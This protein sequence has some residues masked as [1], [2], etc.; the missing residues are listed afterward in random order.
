[1]IFSIIIPM[2]NAES[3]LDRCLSS[4]EQQ[5]FQ[6]YQVIIVDDGSTDH[7]LDIA[8]G[9][10]LRDS[11]FS[12]I[13]VPHGGTGAARNRG[14]AQAVG[15]YIL[16]LD[17]DDYWVKSD[18]LLDLQTRI[19]NHPTD[20]FMFQMLKVTDDG[21]VLKRYTKPA[22]Y[23]DNMVLALKDIYQDLVKDGQVLASACNKCVRKALLREKNVRFREDVLG[24]DIDWALQ[25]FSN[26]QTIY[27]L[28]LY[29]YAYTQH[30]FQSR[31]S[32][33]NAPDDL[34]SVVND[35]S[36]RL[37]QGNISHARAVAGLTAFEYGICMGNNHL[38]SDDKKRIMKDNIYLLK[39]GLDR[40]T[41]LIYRF[42][43]VFG[44][45]LT[46]LAI[47]VYLVIR[48]IW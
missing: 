26:A 25:L 21:V 27:L 34:V 42:Y 37:K 15:E 20:I 16:F 9:Y 44:Y 13:S 10:A 41:K 14:L 48:R 36:A 23:H 31:S 6:D 11:R 18:L 19:T 3:T 43:K 28:N 4:I 39:Y 46:C 12:V 1:M 45:G 17:A 2:L 35:W 5:S 32:R 30:K 7:S 24:E 40:K 8:N 38:L 47:R 22:F 33:E 29:A